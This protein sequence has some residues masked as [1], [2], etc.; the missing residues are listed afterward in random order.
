MLNKHPELRQKLLTAKINKTP[1]E[2]MNS[3]VK[4][5]LM[6]VATVLILIFFFFNKNPNFL[7][8]LIITILISLRLIY[9]MNFR[10][11]DM[12]I[13]RRGKDIDREVL[14]AGRFLL[15]KLN[16]GQPL[17]NAIVDASKTF[18]VANKYFKEIVRDKELGTPLENALENAANYSA[19]KRFK[20][21]LFNINNA[22]KIGIDAS[23]TLS[24]ILDE[25]ADEQ[26]IEIQRYGKKLN[27]LT[28]FYMLLAIILPSLG[29]TMAVVIS[30]MLPNMGTMI[31]AMFWIFGALIIIINVIFI[32]LFR[33]A[34]PNVN[35]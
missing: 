35:I 17:I 1:E 19:S 23:K 13:I 8:I 24:S 28:M 9:T 6:E 5:T 7:I 12:A 27:S 16:S 30:S 20:K 3:V 33:G 21:I 22:I 31:G 32:N 29:M 34:R 14:F 2:Y 11:A 4:I 26:L 10:A 15:I 25:I 18:G